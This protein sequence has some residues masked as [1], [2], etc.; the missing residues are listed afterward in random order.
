MYLY[1]YRCT[2][3]LLQILKDKDMQTLYC[4]CHYFA[5]ILQKP[6]IHFSGKALVVVLEIARAFTYT[7]KDFCL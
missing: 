6:S 2:S 4:G 1:I 5:R 3:R 7:C